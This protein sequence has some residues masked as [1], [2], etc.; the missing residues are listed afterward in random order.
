MPMTTESLNL[1][2]VGA[3]EVRLVDQLPEP[4]EVPDTVV[5]VERSSLQAYAQSGDDLWREWVGGSDFFRVVWRDILG[6]D[7]RKIDESAGGLG[8]N[9][10]TEI[11]ESMKEVQDQLEM[12]SGEYD[13]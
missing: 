11:I 12:E 5:V 4:T 3:T 10:A 2:D 7:S 8:E 6:F 13:E 9:I 1:E